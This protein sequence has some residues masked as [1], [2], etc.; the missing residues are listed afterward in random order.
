[1]TERNNKYLAQIEK[2]LKTIHD[3]TKE[4]VY[5]V[6]EFRDILSEIQLRSALALTYLEPMIKDKNQGE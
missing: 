2:Q 4:E 6:E 1:M 3:A 5:D